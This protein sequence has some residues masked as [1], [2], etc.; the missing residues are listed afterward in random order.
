VRVPG[1]T[2]RITAAV[3]GT[4]GTTASLADIVFDSDPSL[5]RGEIMS[6]LIADV[7]PG[8][9]PELYR[10]QGDNDAR[11]R[12]A[13]QDAIA[14]LAASP[15]SS[16]IDRT[17]RAALRVDAVRITPSLVSPDPL[18]SRL[19]PCAQIQFFQRIGARGNLQYGRSLCSTSRGEIILFEYDAT[20]RFSWLLSRNEDQAYAIEVR[21][22]HAF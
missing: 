6:L 8:E 21:V 19:E 18:S 20:D 10:A 16:T 9:S 3:N 7:P 1:E 5:S 12:Q 14:Q 13:V 17:L 22:R 15:V 11:Q 2:Y 4:Y